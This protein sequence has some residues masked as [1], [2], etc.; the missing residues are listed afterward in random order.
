MRGSRQEKYVFP[1]WS[2][3]GKE[4]PCQRTQLGWRRWT[5]LQ[6]HRISRHHHHPRTSAANCSAFCNLQNRLVHKS[7][8]EN[9]CFNLF[10]RDKF[11]KAFIP[12]QWKQFQFPSS[13]EMVAVLVPTGATDLHIRTGPFPWI[14]MHL[15]GRTACTAGTI[16][17][18]VPGWERSVVLEGASPSFHTQSGSPNSSPLVFPSLSVSAWHNSSVHV[19][20]T[21]VLHKKSVRSA[22]CLVFSPKHEKAIVLHCFNIP[23]LHRKRLIRKDFLDQC[24]QTS[25]GQLL[26]RFHLSER[27]QFVSFT[28]K[29]RFHTRASWIEDR[30][31]ERDRESQ[32]WALKGKW[33]RWPRRT[34]NFFFCVILC[35]PACMNHSLC[36]AMQPHK[37]WFRTKFLGRK[38]LPGT[39]TR[40]NAS[41]LAK[42]C[43]T[44]FFQVAI[45]NRNICTYC[46]CV[47]VLVRA[48]V[49]LC[50]CVPIYLSFGLFL[51]VRSCLRGS[52]GIEIFPLSSSLLDLQKI[53]ENWKTVPSAGWELCFRLE[54]S[55]DNFGDF[56]HH[57]QPKDT[58]KCWFLQ[59]K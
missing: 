23:F 32:Y 41:H 20:K 31:R 55:V 35:N 59:V 8:E 54:F 12:F 50:V 11:V 19:W 14:Q 46:A 6:P 9:I 51:Q 57:K 10:T 56:P 45:T 25:R 15:K 5:E 44:F 18:Q 49:C 29:I 16:T 4:K 17:S 27:Y 39:E 47:C 58:P 42:S 28:G 1:E 24:P 38:S 7:L 52:A 2:F 53:T 13:Q 30:E 34:P 48:R 3:R 37:L 22:K 26:A 43:K 40:N 21:N 36:L 33:K